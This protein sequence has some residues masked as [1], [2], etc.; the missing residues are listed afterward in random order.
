MT[1]RYKGLSSLVERIAQ[2]PEGFFQFIIKEKPVNNAVQSNLLTKCYNTAT[3]LLYLLTLNEKA[4]DKADVICHDQ[5]YE[6]S[7]TQEE[8]IKHFTELKKDIEKND[9]SLCLYYILMNVA[10][11]DCPTKKENN[12]NYLH[13]LLNDFKRTKTFPGHVF[14]LEKVPYIDK[15]GVRTSK[16]FLYQSY[17]NKYTL[18]DYLNKNGK[19]FEI[20]KDKVLSYI[21]GMIKLMVEPKWTKETSKFWKEFTHVN[22][23]DFNECNFHRIKPCYLKFKMKDIRIILNN[24]L[25]YLNGKLKEVNGKI[26]ESNCTYYSVDFNY[27][28]NQ[29]DGLTDKEK[30]LTIIE[31]KEYIKE[32]LD[33]IVSLNFIIN[34]SNR[35]T[36]VN[37][38]IIKSKTLN[39]VNKVDKVS[40]KSTIKI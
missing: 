5:L 29:Y 25:K 36:S 26:K 37:K 30:P 18:K 27:E 39:K 16:Y 38:S 13:N 21:E 14:L 7:I 23:S 11:M 35:K 8:K 20:S 34:N 10:D 33:E 4:L 17:I 31:L 12:G 24:Y 19:T 6:K 15:N 28:R 1:K 40:N 3:M 9:N 2:R 22:S 32:I